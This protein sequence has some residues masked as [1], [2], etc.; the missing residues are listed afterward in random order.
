MNHKE[1]SII[2]R[3]VSQPIGDFYVSTI[4]ACDIV[5]MSKA[6]IRRFVDVDESR[7]GIQRAGSPARA[8]EIKKFIESADSSFPNSIILNLDSDHLLR[9][10]HVTGIDSEDFCRLY[11]VE[12]EST[13]GIIDGQHRL[14]GFDQHNCRNFELIVTIFLG[15]DIE[16]QAYL[17]STINMKQVKVNKSLVYDLFDVADTPS[18]QKTA[19]KIVKLLNSEPDSPLHRRIKLLGVTPTLDGEVLYK[20]QLTQG[21]VVQRIIGLISKDPDADRSAERRG[22]EI[23]VGEDA[24]QDGLI[25]RKYYKERKDWAIYKIMLNYF[26]AVRKTYTDEWNDFANPLSRTIGLGAL[27][28]LLVPLYIDG[29]SEGDVTESYFL[30][31]MQQIRNRYDEIIVEHSWLSITFRN[32]PAAGSGERILGNY[33]KALNGVND[34]DEFVTERRDQL[35]AQGLVLG[36]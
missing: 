24:L 5:R 29:A 7:T 1:N 26:Q 35:K 14:N 22:Q 27:V 21:T 18:P 28:S 2:V 9:L 34:L 23:V 16:L 3:R 32:F 33:F 17:F 10:E 31:R 30:H 15:L 13:F 11:F 12:N 19:H 8:R 6:N 36:E 4:P 20:A 25:F